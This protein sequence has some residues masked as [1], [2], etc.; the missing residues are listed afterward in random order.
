[1]S[2]TIR[3]TSPTGTT[4]QLEISSDLFRYRLFVECTRHYPLYMVYWTVVAGH[5]T[6]HVREEPTERSD[7]TLVLST[8]QT[9]SP[10]TFRVIRHEGDPPEVSRASVGNKAGRPDKINRARGFGEQNTS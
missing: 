8:G 1:M 9:L 3:T 4:D 5:S 7:G 6:Q 2:T 10:N